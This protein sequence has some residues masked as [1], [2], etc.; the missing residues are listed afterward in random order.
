MRRRRGSSGEGAG[1]GGRP[2]RRGPV[3][4]LPLLGS[5]FGDVGERVEVGGRDELE[6]G[7]SAR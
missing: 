2:L 4:A 6:A 3:P 5:F 7:G 1:A